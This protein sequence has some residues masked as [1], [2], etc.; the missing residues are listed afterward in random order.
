MSKEQRI[1][2]EEELFNMLNLSIAIGVNGFTKD[3]VNPNSLKEMISCIPD[4][5]LERIY[6]VQKLIELNQKAIDF[7]RYIDYNYSNYLSE[8]EKFDKWR[9]YYKK[10]Y[11]NE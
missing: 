1:I 9:A 6:F 7:I 5:D 10:G 11:N 2:Y 8:D 4:V 3:S